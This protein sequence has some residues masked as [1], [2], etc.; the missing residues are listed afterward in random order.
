M[1]MILTHNEYIQCPI[2]YANIIDNAIK[3]AISESSC[4]LVAGD[5]H[6]SYHPAA[7]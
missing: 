7:S 1:A 2:S 3:D 5:D 4:D 6:R